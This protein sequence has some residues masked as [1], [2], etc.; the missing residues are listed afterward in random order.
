[1]DLSAHR[2][3]VG[4]ATDP[5]RGCVLVLRL[6]RENP[7]WGHRRI[8]GELVTLGHTLSAATVWNILTRAGL[9]PAPRRTG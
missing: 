1:M 8:H 7:T 9:D 5:G 4:S 3:V 6:A 2:E